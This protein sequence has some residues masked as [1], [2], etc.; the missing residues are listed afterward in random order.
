MPLLLIEFLLFYKG[1]PAR[2]GWNLVCENEDAYAHAKDQQNDK[3][4]RDNMVVRAF[5]S[6][7]FILF[8]VAQFSILV[9]ESVSLCSLKK[10][11]V[12]L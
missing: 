4:G 11:F 7:V 2:K 3:S 8:I 12:L 5:N 9:C 10:D 6:C 1:Y